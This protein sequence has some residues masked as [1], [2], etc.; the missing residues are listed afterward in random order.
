[1]LNEF[2]KE[3]SKNDYYY[4]ILYL[5]LLNYDFKKNNSMALIESIIALKNLAI[6][7]DTT[8]QEF[9]KQELKEH[10]KNLN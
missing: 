6:E 10:K 4:A 9:Y 5:E 1:M 3:L 7:Q 8:I 2:I